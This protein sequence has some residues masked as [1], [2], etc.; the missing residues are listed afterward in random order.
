MDRRVGTTLAVVGLLGVTLTGTVFAQAKGKPA[1]PANVAVTSQVQD[2]N[3]VISFELRSDG[4][5]PYVNANGVISQ[6]YGSSGDWELDLSSQSVRGIDLTLTTVDGSPSG[7][8]SGRYNAR[9][10]SRCFAADGGITGY[11]QVPEGS[12]N[13]RCAMR[14]NFTAGGTDYFLVMSPLYAGTTWVTVSCPADADA[15]TTCETWSVAPDASAVTPVA[16][17]YRVS[18]SKETLVGNYVLHFALTA[19]R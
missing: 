4:L 3:E 8:L 14:V 9:L 12:S 1:P 18:R 2:G 7:V 17:L 5:G 19:T 11:L 15:N 6:I 16:A 13:S 10:V